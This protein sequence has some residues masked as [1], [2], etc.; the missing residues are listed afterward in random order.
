MPPHSL[1]TDEYT[2]AIRVRDVSKRFD[3]TVALDGFHLDVHAGHVMTLLGPSGSGKTTALRLI[4]GFDRP[5]GGS[6][7][8]EGTP[9]ADA[10]TFAPPE[11]RRVG[12][13]FQDYALFPHLTVAR[14]VAYGV[15]KSHRSRRVAETLE[16]VGLVGKE[17]RLPHELSGG[18]QQRVALAR[19]L[20]PEPKVILLDEPF[21]NLDAALRSRVRAEVADI[22]RQA[23]ATAVFVTHDQE[24]ALSMS[25]FVA[26]MHDGRVVQA[27]RPSD[28]YRS[29]VDEWVAGF[30]GDADFLVGDANGRSVATSAGTFPTDLTGAVRVM[31]RPEVVSLVPDATG[32][33]VVDARQFFGHDQLVTVS[34]ADGTRLRARLGPSPNLEPGDKVLVS[35]GEATTFPW[36][37]SLPAG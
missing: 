25:D 34:L 11:R 27:A 32:P 28:L 15:S 19:A 4:A 31:I 12:M 8:I 2:L 13:V 17:E 21:S 20:A 18:E 1:P 33:A 3:G 16:L 37:E 24:E 9:V 14:N 36:R 23:G 22:L 10:T 29:P 7:E 5:D 26:V 35:V 6:I 30:L